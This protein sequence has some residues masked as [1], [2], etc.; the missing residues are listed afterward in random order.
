MRTMLECR[1]MAEKCE[2]LAA[3]SALPSSRQAFLEIAD[4]WRALSR[5]THITRLE[6]ERQ[7]PEQL[8]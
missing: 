5:V 8:N 2:R 1:A 7:P 6:I 3:Y 4:Q